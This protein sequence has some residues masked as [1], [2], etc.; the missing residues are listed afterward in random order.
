MKHWQTAAAALLSGLLAAAAFP[1][2]QWEPAVWMALVPLIFAAAEASPRRA[3]AAGLL[4][5]AVFWLLSISW[6]IRVTALGWAVLALYCALYTALFAV[7]VSIL[8]RLDRTS[9]LDAF[10]RLAGAAF[11]WTGLEFIR[12]R[13][14]TGFPWNGLGVALY[15]NLPVIQAASWGG[16]S[17]VT[18]AAVWVNVGVASAL[19]TFLR[20]GRTLFWIAELVAAGAVLLGWMTFGLIQI[21]APLDEGPPL[22]TA[23]IQPAVPQGVKWDAQA[24]QE[25][26]DRLLSLSENALRE[27]EPDL[28]VWPETAIPDFLRESPSSYDLVRRLVAAGTPLLLGGMDI[29]WRDDETPRYFNTSFLIDPAGRIV[30]QYDK[31]HLVLFGETVPFH[32]VF[33]FLDSLAPIEGSFTA[34]TTGTVFR[35]PGREDAFSVLI[36]FEDSIA[37]LARAQV[38][39]GSRL[40]INQTNDAWF[41]TSSASVQHMAQCVFRCV[42]N[43]V[44]A[45]RCANSGISCRIDA[46]GRIREQ[47]GPGPGFEPVA[48]FLNAEVRPPDGFAPPT[49]YTRAG[50]WFGGASL[51]L[52]AVPFALLLLLRR[53]PGGLF[54]AG[55]TSADSG[56]AASGPAM[57]FD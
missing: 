7:G 4:A 32:G 51:V 52:S 54:G 21:R 15:R 19:R 10:L 2:L 44:P 16:L 40:L 48:G 6:L 46:R 41:D 5:G 42:E 50:E 30:R 55:P 45:V 36:C 18:F 39:A 27:G 57:L 14:F 13:L 26:R 38:R 23:L 11:L 53:P 20:P 3:A 31:Q 56:P 43:R 8:F 17:A 25:I 49:L 24:E 1:P 37:S 29:E 12:Y 22:R 35:L 34:G 33:P 47:L 28:L 9:P